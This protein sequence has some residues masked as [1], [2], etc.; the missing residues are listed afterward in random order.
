MNKSVK[1]LLESRITTKWWLDK[2]ISDTEKI[3]S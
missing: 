2:D 1:D 3:Q